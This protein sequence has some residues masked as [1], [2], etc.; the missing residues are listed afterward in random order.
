MLFASS[1]HSGLKMDGAGDH[2]HDDRGASN[3][4]PIPSTSDADNS[5]NSSSNSHRYHGLSINVDLDCNYD[6]MALLDSSRGDATNGDAGAGTSDY[7]PTDDLSTLT[8]SNGP[9]GGVSSLRKSSKNIRALKRFSSD[10]GNDSTKT[11]L[12]LDAENV[13]FND[14]RRR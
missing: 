12:T 10:A 3:K 8:D 9:S 4:A 1:S 13:V 14:S 5:S 2:Y 6:T 7:G 11:P